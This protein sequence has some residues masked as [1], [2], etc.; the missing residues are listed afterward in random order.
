MMTFDEWIHQ[1]IDD[2]YGGFIKNGDRLTGD[3]DYDIV[4]WIYDSAY[5]EGYNSANDAFTK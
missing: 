1:K 2:G 4:K 3:Y 5:D